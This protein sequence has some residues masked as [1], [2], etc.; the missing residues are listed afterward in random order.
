S[1]RGPTHHA[2]CELAR[3]IGGGK[4][5]HRPGRPPI[6]LRP[7]QCPM[8]R[9]DSCTDAI[10]L[11]PTTPR[12]LPV[13]FELQSDL[14]SNAMA[15]TKPR[16]REAFFAA[17]QRNFTDPGVNSRVI[18]IDNKRGPAIVRNISRFQLHG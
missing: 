3:G 14:Q 15:G 4:T 2:R 12:D 16:T 10:R 5:A 6:S 7:L 11:R 8:Q 13:L 17:W 18:E 1:G 9:R